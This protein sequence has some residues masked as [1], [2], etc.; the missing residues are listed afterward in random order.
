MSELNLNNFQLR[1]E[2]ESHIPYVGKAY[3]NNE[4][5]QNIIQKI[6]Q[7][8]FKDALLLL[9]ENIKNPILA[10]DSLMLK[11]EFLMSYEFYNDALNTFDKLLMRDSNNLYAHVGLAHIGYILNDKPLRSQSFKNMTPALANQIQ[12]TISFIETS[13]T[14]CYSNQFSQELDALCVFG[15]VI[16]EDGYLTPKLKLR[17]D[18]T[19]DLADENPSSM[20]LVS[21]AAVQNKYN[22]A[23][24]MSEYLMSKGIPSSRIIKLPFARDT[25]GNIIEFVNEII[26]N[27]FHTVCAVTSMYHLQR[28]WMSLH[29][30]LNN[31]N[32]ST[33]VYASHP[34][35]TFM[36][37]KD[38]LRE[39]E[40]TY[41]TVMRASE[42]FSV[43]DINQF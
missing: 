42:L 2:T 15:Y 13:E 26:K 5:F 10:V 22:E 27:Q 31:K 6:K 21:G 17:L 24:K 33:H 43:H 39:I 23:E 16:T 34:S 18:H 29:K 1:K 12:Q 36:S 8:Q 9:N 37:E 4:H 14:P 25:V 35:Q 41:P 30:A 28:S 40:L 11:G 20:I 32:H 38:R 7:Y 3:E 19:L